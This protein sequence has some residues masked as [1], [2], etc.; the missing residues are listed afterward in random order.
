[1]APR[2]DT[3]VFVEALFTSLLM[4]WAIHLIFPALL[5]VSIGFIFGYIILQGRN[6]YN[7]NFNLL[8]LLVLSIGLASPLFLEFSQTQTTAFLSMAIVLLVIKLAFKFTGFSLT[9]Q[10]T[11]PQTSAMVTAIESK[12]IIGFLISLLNV[13]NI[14]LFALLGL[15]II[16]LVLLDLLLYWLFGTPTNQIF[17]FLGVF[18]LGMI[19]IVLNIKD[20][21][22]IGTRKIKARFSSEPENSQL[23][24]EEVARE[25]YEGID[26]ELPSTENV[27]WTRTQIRELA[28]DEFY[29]HCIN[30][31]KKEADDEEFHIDQLEPPDPFGYCIWSIDGEDD[32]AFVE[33]GIKKIENN[34]YTYEDLT[35]VIN[36]YLTER[37]LEPHFV[38]ITTTSEVKYEEKIRIFSEYGLIIYDIDLLRRTFHEYDL[39]KR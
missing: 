13:Q 23:T 39:A 16:P 26:A 1:M 5:A 30:V 34:E 10:F 38:V 15:A 35:G 25:V 31:A 3:S 36:Q 9:S 19:A 17:I 29:Q 33:L 8:G 24:P 4:T 37:Q 11:S 27:I 20:S 22:K 28:N 7:S 6:K 12:S 21:V 18:S 14:A 2:G 32:L